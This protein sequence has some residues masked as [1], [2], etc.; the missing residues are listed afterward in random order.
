MLSDMKRLRKERGFTQEQLAAMVNA[1]KRQ[2]G[3]W[4]RGENELPM[5]YGVVI[6][7]VLNCTLDELSGRQCPAA[8]ISNVTDDERE[9][10]ELYRS[11]SA[12]GQNAV[13]VGLRE[14]AGK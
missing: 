11:L 3:A 8:T 6:A 12:R 4:E 1:T 2:I 5:D 7:D 10:L 13:L 14:Y 9:L